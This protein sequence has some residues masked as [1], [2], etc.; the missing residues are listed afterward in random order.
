MAAGHISSR[1]AQ[2]LANIPMKIPL[3]VLNRQC[4]SGIQACAVVFNAIKNGEYDIGIAGGVESMSTGDM[5]GIFDLEKASKNVLQ[6]ETATNCLLPM[7]VISDNICSEYK[8]NRQ[9]LDQFSVDSH[10]KALKSLKEGWYKDEILPITVNIDGKDVV[11]DKDDGARETTLESLSK[12]KPSFNKN[13]LTTAGNSSQ[14]TDGAA[15]VVLARRSVA[16]Q[17][18]L[19]ILAKFSGF[20]VEGC[21]P[22][23]MGIGPIY[24]IPRLLKRLDL[25]VEDID[26]WE[27]N[28]AFA[29]QCTFC[30][31]YL[32]IPYEKVN[33]RGG[34]IAIGH[35]LGCTGARQVSTLISELKR[36][37][38]SKG[39]ISMCIGTGMG[40]AA[41]I[42]L[43]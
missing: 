23:L 12:L 36:T 7:G 21:K 11:V 5:G 22:E 4:S 37:K 30:V 24:A 40:A 2:A 16:K 27:L 38:K 32:K 34:A 26:V 41:L 17:L 19:T 42:E 9:K 15:V 10:N 18:G 20:A 25:K 29:S 14:L 31:D 1:V 6:N 3:Q 43:E 28:E 13:G 39:V 35:P 33:P 8:L